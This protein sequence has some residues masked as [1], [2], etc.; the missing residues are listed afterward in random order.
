MSFGVQAKMLMNRSFSRG[1]KMMFIED[2]LS[3]IMVI[4]GIE[5]GD[6]DETEIE[7]FAEVHAGR[8]GGLAD[9]LRFCQVDPVTGEKRGRPARSRASVLLD[10]SACRQTKS[11]GWNPAWIRE[12]TVNR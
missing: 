8:P 6:W 3:D 2:V 10:K 1:H 12:A 5:F 9:C 11:V 4:K 7:Q